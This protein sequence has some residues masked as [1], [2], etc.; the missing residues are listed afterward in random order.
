MAKKTTLLNFTRY[1]DVSFKVTNKVGGSFKSLIVNLNAC[2]CMADLWV[3]QKAADAL[4]GGG[5]M[6]DLQCTSE[7]N[8]DSFI[9][10]ISIGAWRRLL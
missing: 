3:I 4:K 8:L 10:F 6:A 9:F 1:N 2:V 7:K 5:G